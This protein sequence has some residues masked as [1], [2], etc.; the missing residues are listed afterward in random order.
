[1]TYIEV[2]IFV[3]WK[4]DESLPVDIGKDTYW[5]MTS[6]IYHTALRI[7]L[8]EG[9]VKYVNMHEIETDGSSRRV[10]RVIPPKEYEG[11][12]WKEVALQ[13]RWFLV[14]E[15]MAKEVGVKI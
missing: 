5:D 1:M 13:D 3:Q 10:V 2:R 6:A 8:L 14:C 15:F 7:R 4:G 11:R 9:Q 12:L